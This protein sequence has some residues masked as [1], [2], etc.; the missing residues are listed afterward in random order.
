MVKIIPLQ[1]V[2]VV[3]AVEMSVAQMLKLHLS[4]KIVSVAVVAEADSSFPLPFS[5]CRLEVSLP[6]FCMF[7][8]LYPLRP[9]P[10]MPGSCR[11]L[12]WWFP[13]LALEMM[14]P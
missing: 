7:E 6:H 3:V 5:G 13:A 12:F 9:P 4:S 8:S 14:T 2:P 10:E 1:L 11:R